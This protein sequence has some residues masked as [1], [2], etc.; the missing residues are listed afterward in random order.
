MEIRGY[1]IRGELKTT[2]SGF[3][4]WGFADKGGKT[5]FIKEFIDPV[6][7]V[8]TDVLEPAMI[9]RKKR[10]CKEFE[11]RTALLYREINNCS[12][13]NLVYIEDFF[14]EG[15]HYYLTMEKVT[16][17]SM[18]LIKRLPR[19]DR[20]RVCKT[21]I[22]SI[23]RMHQRGI[24]HADIKL[25]NIMFREL[26]SGKIT[27]KVID[28]D[29]SFWE[30]EPPDPEEEVHGDPVYM[31]PE[32]FRM[33]ET[34][35]GALTRAIDVFALGLVF[36][37]IFT[38]ELPGFDRS[39]YDY[40]FESVLDGAGLSYSMEIPEEWRNMIIRMTEKDVD[41]RISLA[42]AE[43]LW[44]HSGQEL[45]STFGSTEGKTAGSASGAEEFFTA[46]GD[47]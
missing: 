43:Q 36:H 17:V 29:N 39:A 45:R 35:E 25:D 38:G 5:Y 37:Q 33:M 24:V 14:R 46:A 2:N 8:C 10:I 34:E 7:P 6:Y 9:E 23:G 4:K 30:S 3:S 11:D 44:R 15:S 19:E 21:L 42:E 26:P 18:S 40:P 20:I 12:D 22:H 28:F 47:L 1:Q 31:A 41:R 13:G 32:T 16:A 27:A